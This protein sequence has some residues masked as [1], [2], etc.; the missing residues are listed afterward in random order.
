MT[1]PLRLLRAQIA[2]G[3]LVL[4]ASL[5]VTAPAKPVARPAVRA[6]VPAAPL[7]RPA[8]WKL[9]DADTTIYLFGTIHLLPKGLR[10][11]AGPIESAF[12]TSGEFVSEIADG[13]PAA[14]QRVMIVKA[15]LP[16]DQTLRGMLSPAEKISLE[17]ALAGNRLAPNAVDRFKPWYAAVYL[18]TVPLLSAGYAAENGVEATLEARSKMLGQRRVGLE[19]IEYQLGLFD[20]LPADVQRRYLVE[21]AKHSPTIRA[22]LTAMVEE[23]KRGNA[24]KLAELMNAD[25]DDPHMV[26]VLLTGRNRAWTQWIRGRMDRPGKVFLAVGTGHLAGRNSVLEQ[27]TALGYKVTRL[28]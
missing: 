11:F 13:D 8:L 25:E 1:K 14:V 4:L 24:R 26:E 12:N 10:W 7:A 9:E 17:K 27:L 22:Q 20:G 18:S 2:M 5:S 21:I 15:F 6:A 28:Q 3:A 23:W 19:T 16:A